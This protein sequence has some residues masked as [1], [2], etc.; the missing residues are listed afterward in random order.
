MADEP[1]DPDF[2]QRVDDF[3]DQAQEALRRGV[4]KAGALAHDKADDIADM[5]DKAGA[6]VDQRTD[7]KYA[8]QIHRVKDGLNQG[9]AKLAEQRSDEPDQP[10]DR[11]GGA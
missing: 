5:L 11:D 6:K 9:V 8:D 10:G 7:G 1:K 2:R 4:A 3:A